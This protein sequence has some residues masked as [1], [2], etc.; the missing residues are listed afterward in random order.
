[1]ASPWVEDALRA[2]AGTYSPGPGVTGGSGGD[3]VEGYIRSA[4]SQRGIDPDVAVRVA[5]SEGGLV[6]NRRGTFSTGSSWWPFQLHYGGQGYER[7][8]NVAGM[9]N[10]FTA[11]TGYQPGDPNAWRASTDYALDRARESGWG[12]WYGARN[13]GVTGYQ[14]INRNAPRATSAPAA[15]AS[16]GDLPPWVRDLVDRGEAGADPNPARSGIDAMRQAE[17]GG[18]NA[19][20]WLRDALANSPA[21]GGYRGPA[22]TDEI[23][24]VAGQAWGRVNNPFGGAQARS[25]GATVALQPY[26]TG[27]DLTA[28]YGAPVVAPVSG[29]IEEV[30]DAPDERDRNANHGWGGMTLLRGD[31]GYY[32][33]LSHAQ[34]GSIATRPGQRVQQGQRLQNVG[35][36]G[37][38]TGAHLDA[39]KFDRP[40]HFVDIAAGRGGT[41]GAP[42]ASGLGAL[43]AAALGALPPW[44]RDA[45]GA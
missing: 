11:A 38:T 41:V 7:F 26:N 5:Q 12:Q 10:A 22:Q 4:A 37:N 13:V 44:V 25:A 1:M 30:F 15:A 8:G 21:P 20:P 28:S 3:D 32:Y 43:G 14:G 29:T 35:V 19:T 36:S 6:P 34:P 24:P 18:P 31:N 23:W 33:R 39:E 9:G 16:G 45:L 42:A 27:A 2:G 17:A 40:G